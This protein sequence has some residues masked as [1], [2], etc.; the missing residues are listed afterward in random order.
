MCFCR[1]HKCNQLIILVHIMKTHADSLIDK[2]HFSICSYTETAYWM[3]PSSVHVCML[4]HVWVWSASQW[5]RWPYWACC[6]K[7]WLWLQ[8]LPRCKKLPWPYSLSYFLYALAFIYFM[9]FIV[10][11]VDVQSCSW[12]VQAKLGPC[13]CFMAPLHLSSCIILTLT[14]NVNFAVIVCSS[15]PVALY[16]KHIKI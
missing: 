11:N 13:S 4:Q 7:K 3:K 6:C 16:G 12:C 10:Y 14:V 2:S 8:H 1:E 5:L 15:K 9:E